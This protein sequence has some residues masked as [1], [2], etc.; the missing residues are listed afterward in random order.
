[1]RAS[2]SFLAALQDVFA[3]V[4]KD[5]KA[6]FARA[7]AAAKGRIAAA[8]AAVKQ[9]LANAEREAAQALQASLNKAQAQAAKTENKVQADLAKA[10]MQYARLLAL[11]QKAV[12]FQLP[13]GP[14]PGV[15]MQNGIYRYTIKG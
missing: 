13:G 12:W 9:A 10:N 4:A 3:G 2:S 1:M 6:R 11:D 5:V 8:V 7:E 14:A 15:T